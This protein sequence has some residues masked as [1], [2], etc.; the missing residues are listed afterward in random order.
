MLGRCGLALE[1]LRLRQ[2]EAPEVRGV[3]GIP[4]FHHLGAISPENAMRQRAEPL[5][6]AISVTGWEFTLEAGDICD[7]SG[8]EILSLDL[9]T[10]HGMPGRK[11]VLKKRRHFAHQDC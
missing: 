2:A 1:P 9:E 10:L 3:S 4:L 8:V 11:C 6:V 5:S 7:L